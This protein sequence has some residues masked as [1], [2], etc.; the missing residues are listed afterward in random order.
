[1]TEGAPESRPTRD[2]RKAIP[3]SCALHRGPRGFAN[4]MVEKRGA[5]IVLPEEHQ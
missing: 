3:V 1:M 2:N 5:E 4:L